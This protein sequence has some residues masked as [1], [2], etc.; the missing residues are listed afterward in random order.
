[1]A[2]DI[3]QKTNVAA[4]NPSVV[5]T[6]MAQLKSVRTNG[7]YCGEI[8]TPLSHNSDVTTTIST[9]TAT[10]AGAPTTV[11][12]FA[13]PPPQTTTATPAD[14]WGGDGWH[15]ALV[16]GFSFELED[17]HPLVEAW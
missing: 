1:L 15:G 16:F 12:P 3:G 11:I 8:K 10:S 17:E 4:A 14:N 2:K 6:M 13:L 5:A 7:G 9:T